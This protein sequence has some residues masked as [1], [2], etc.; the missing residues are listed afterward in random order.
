MKKKATARFK[1]RAQDRIRHAQT[2][3]ERYLTDAT[4]VK[5]TTGGLGYV[6]QE[7]GEPD[8]RYRDV[9]QVYYV[10]VLVSTGEVF[11]ENYRRGKPFHFCLGVGEVI[12]GWDIGVGLL[13][14]GAVADLYVPAAL[15]YGSDGVPG[16]PPDSELIFS[17]EI[18]GVK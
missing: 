17:V 18:A 11:D 6:I 14:V 7:P 9:V 16:I 3:R 10:G 8:L 1:A 15:A 2:V 5:R 4:H 12:R 13:G